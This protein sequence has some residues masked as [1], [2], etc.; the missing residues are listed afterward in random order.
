[1]GDKGFL[2]N[3][4]H[5]VKTVTQISFAIGCSSRKGRCH[6]DR[7]NLYSAGHPPGDSYVQIKLKTTDLIFCPSGKND[8]G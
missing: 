5:V 1:M 8:L 2:L 6:L 4:D 7:G 3:K